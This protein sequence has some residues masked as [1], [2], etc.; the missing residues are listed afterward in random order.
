MS[1]ILFW[2]L[3]K[4]ASLVFRISP[5]PVFSLTNFIIQPV[6]IATAPPILNHTLGIIIKDAPIV[7]KP[8]VIAFVW[9]S[10]VAPSLLYSSRALEAPYQAVPT[11]AATDIA[12]LHN[13]S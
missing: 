8:L 4:T 10:K 5:I 2:Y 3:S 12:V 7:D 6:A 1:A 11:V 13:S 9:S